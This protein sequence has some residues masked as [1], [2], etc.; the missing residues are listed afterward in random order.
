MLPLWAAAGE[1]ESGQIW[2]HIGRS[3]IHAI[4]GQHWMSAAK[5]SIKQRFCTVPTQAQ[6]FAAQ[7]ESFRI[8]QHFHLTQE[9]TCPPP[10]RFFHR[11]ALH[12]FAANR[13]IDCLPAAYNSTTS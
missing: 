5:C 11:N 10:N 6:L 4:R 12:P 3:S 1:P 8:V 2:P 9:R 7:S 13:E